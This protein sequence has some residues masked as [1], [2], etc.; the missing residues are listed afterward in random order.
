MVTGDAGFFGGILK[1]SILQSGN[2]V[3]S[4]DIVPDQDEHAN[5][6]EPQDRYT[7]S[8]GLDPAFA[9]AAIERCGALRRQLA[10]GSEDAKDLWTSNVDS[11]GDVM[12]AMRNARSASTFHRPAIA[13]GARPSAVPS[14]DDACNP[15]E[16]YGR[17]KLEG[18]RIIREYT[19]I[20]C[21][22]LAVPP[23]W[24]LAGSACFPFCSI[25]SIRDGRIGGGRRTQP[26]SIRCLP[27]AGDACVLAL[28]YPHSTPSI[29]VRQREVNRGSIR[30]R[31]PQFQGRGK[32]R[33]AARGPAIAAMK[34]RIT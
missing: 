9:S 29:S 11:T 16:L 7:G 10:H 3:V 17:S 33:H 27:G 8:G 19:D 28:D 12:D 30:I 32:S 1:R 4:V 13:C 24:I 31:N 21:V 14:Q 2:R 20:N 6:D 18:E 15:V 23:V 5:L 34:W 26:V 22:L 25:L